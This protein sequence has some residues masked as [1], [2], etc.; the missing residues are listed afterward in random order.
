MKMLVKI[1]C[2]LCGLYLIYEG[3]SRY[4]F[5]ARSPDGSVGHNIFGFFLPATE[6]ALLLYGGAAVLLGIILVLFGFRRSNSSR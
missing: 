6:T 2:M 4:I 1:L 5:S 3:V